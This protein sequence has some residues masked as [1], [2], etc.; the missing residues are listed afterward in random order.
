MA[1]DG[2]T[3]ALEKVGSPMVKVAAALSAM[4][5][6]ESHAQWPLLQ[7]LP[8]QISVSLTIPVFRVR[9]L[10]ALRVGTVIESEW[11]SSQDVPLRVSDV[12]VFW[13]EFEVVEQQTMAVRL[14]RL[15]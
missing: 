7:T 13:C 11:S 9:D 6:I 1:N 4:T 5:R 3:M 14:T 10:L 2:K 15:Q 12:A 8:M